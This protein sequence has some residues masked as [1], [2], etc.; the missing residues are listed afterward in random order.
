MSRV[1]FVGVYGAGMSALAQFHAMGGGEATGSD[2][3]LDR[4]QASEIRERLER[5]GVGLFAQDGS[6][7]TG[8][9]DA[10]VASTAIE[11]DNPELA[12]A[13]RF[14]VAVEH[15]ADWLA[16][17]VREHRTFAVA[18]TSGKSTVA[19]MLYSILR[20]AGRSPSVI[21]G[22]GLHALE[23]EGWLGNAM[24][25]ESDLLV[26]EADESDGTLPKY[27][28]AVGV[29]LNLGKD[30]KEIEE[31]ER[32]FSA[33]RERSRSFVVNAD[34]ENLARWTEGASTFGFER[35]ALRGENL[36]LRP[37]SSRFSVEGTAF[38]LSLPGRYN[39]SNALAAVCAAKE[40][41]VSFPEAA[42]ALASYR[43]IARRYDV[44]G[45]SGGVRVVDDYAHN[46]DKIR[47][48]LAAARRQANGGGLRVVFQPHGFGP[49]RFLKNDLI[50][51][52]A[53]A[54]GAST[55]ALLKRARPR[56]GR[57]ARPRVPETWFSCSAL[58]IRA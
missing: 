16:R 9:T 50:E 3:F 2:R 23:A 48:V 13:E 40:A 1:H 58:G 51:A 55:R 36:E 29:L 37:A 11:P 15:R 17:I 33:F 8:K 47:A 12:A 10:V 14:G 28:A 42:K 43:G 45:E 21:T 32:I 53:V 18:G 25:G 30:H 26:I 19:A 5:A 27:E 54:G 35:G 44:L 52:F 22:A 46:P 24:R 38:E 56:P 41:G 7:I 49:T 57:S 4:G 20:D 31:L 34:E 39:A 6:G